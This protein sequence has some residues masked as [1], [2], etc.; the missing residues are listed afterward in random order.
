MNEQPPTQ[1]QY[2]ACTTCNGFGYTINK[3]KEHV[4]CHTCHDKPSFFAVFDNEALFWGEEISEIGIKKRH[5]ARKVNLVFNITLMACGVLGLGALAYAG[6]TEFSPNLPD[7]IGLSDFF[8]TPNRFV[9]L[10]WLS[11]GVDCFLMYRLYQESIA[12]KQIDFSRETQEH[13]AKHPLQLPAKPS[14]EKVAKLSHSHKKDISAYFTHEA[15]AAIELSYVVTKQLGHHQITPLH[16]LAALLETQAVSAVMVRLAIQKDAVM[17]SIGRAMSKEG[18]DSGKGVDL[19]LEARHMFFYAYE[20]AVTRKH[21]TVDA[22]ELFSAV[23]KHDSWAQDI[24]YDLEIDQ[25][26]L[27]NTIEWMYI[28]RRLRSQYTEWRSKASKKPKGIMDRAMTAQPSPLLQAIS[29][30]YTTAAVQGAFFPLIGR[31]QEME[32]VMRVLTQRTGNVLLVGPPGVG[33]STILEGVAQMMAAEEVPKKWQDKRFVVLDPGALI[34][35]AE[36]VGAVEGRMLTVIKEIRRAGNILLGIEDVHHLLDMRSTTGSED[37]GS[38]LMNALSQGQIQVL[39][40]TTT[41]EYQQYIANRG[42]FLRRFQIVKMDEMG[43]HDAILVLEAQSARI[44]G[45]Y[46]VFFSYAAIEAAVD[47]TTQFI[48][49]RYLPAKALDIMTEAAGLVSGE[50][51]EGSIVEKEDVAR[52]ISEKT[53]VEVTAITEDEREKLLNLE[54]IMHQRVVGQDEAVGAIASALRRAREGLRDSGRPIASMLFLGPTGVGKTETAKTIAE[55]YF[56]NEQ[57]MIRLDMSEYQEPSALQKLIGGPG[58]RGTLTE[59]IRLKPFSLVL[60]DEF[61][62]AY[63]DVLNIFLQVLDDG[64][65]TDGTGRTIDMSNTMIIATSNAA[66]QQIQNAIAAG[67]TSQQVKTQLMEE[68]LPGMFRPELLNRFDNVVVF[69]PLT[70]AQVTEIATRMIQKMSRTL[71]DQRGVLLKVSQQAVAELAQAGYDPRY[72]A[73]PLRRVLQEVVDDA[74]AKLF[75]EQQVRRK[76]T[77]VIEAGGQIRVER[78]DSL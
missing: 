67:Y 15:L 14:R 60:L 64:R 33:K 77:I 37:A 59:Q 3:S 58:Q 72:G 73:R 42:T 5:I 54:A 70:L 28:Q 45:Q 17:K 65:L 20:E 31:E 61:E 49:D 24:F 41:E 56:G 57:N 29:Q 48:Q 62:K 52:V 11:V 4:V 1:M 44:E 43:K 32:Q 66:T 9:L 27:N 46:K 39:A 23:V 30:D 75:L 35:N 40:T 53:N 12:K 10:F 36:G 50:R 22:I 55:V 25:E 76:D 2:A 69:A 38:I 47:L 19:G 74:V 51:G 8:T 71:F 16:L 21:P 26:H 7:L 63:P 6:Y 78:G 34:A 18:I 68:T 13:K